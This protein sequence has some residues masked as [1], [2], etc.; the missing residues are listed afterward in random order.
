MYLHSVMDPTGVRFSVIGDVLRIETPR[1][2][3]AK[4]FHD[5]LPVC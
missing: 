4:H 2:P 3:W 5:V 1:S